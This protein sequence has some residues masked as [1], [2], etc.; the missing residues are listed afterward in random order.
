MSMLI[1]A[2]LLIN[3]GVFVAYPMSG[4]M[5]FTFLYIS[6]VLW[7]ALA[8]LIGRSVSQLGPWPKFVIVVGFSLAC[9]FCGLSFLPQAD[10]VTALSKFADGVYPD[11]RSVYLG[12]L[13]LGINVPALRPPD[14]PEAEVI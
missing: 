10:K 1:A 14:K 8:V 5:G 3:L 6:A 7:T 13:R 12:L 2:G 11:Q 9:A 4:H